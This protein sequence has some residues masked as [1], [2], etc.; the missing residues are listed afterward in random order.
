MKQ[1]FI[2]LSVIFAFTLTVNAQEAVFNQNFESLEK[3]ENVKKLQKGKF[4]TWGQAIFTVTEEEGKGNNESNKFASSDGTGNAA[5][6]TYRDLEVGATYVFSVA[7][8]MTN[9]KGKA[10]N[11]NYVVNATSGKKD[12]MHKYGQEKLVAP[13]ANEWKEHTL[14]FTVIEGREKVS[15]SVYRWAKNVTL[16]VDDFKL[17]KK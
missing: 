8:K 12:D 14:A 10:S 15:L 16:N 4:T 3:G 6:A 11:A 1:L 2:S 9:V 13:K 5:I 17:V 7:V